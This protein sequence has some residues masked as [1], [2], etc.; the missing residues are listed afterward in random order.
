MR[1][2]PCEPKVGAD[3]E[4]FLTK[5]D[6]VVPCVGLVEGTKDKP[7]QPPDFVKGFALQEDNV[8][9]EFNV[10]PAS[11]LWA[12]EENLRTARKMLKQYT[13]PEH[14]YI[15]VEHNNFIPKDLRSTQAKT[16]GCEPDFDAYSGGE[17]RTFCGVLGNTRTCGGHIHLGGDFN[18][19][20]FVAALFADLLIGTLPDVRSRGGPRA[21][22]YGKAGIY[23][24]KPYGIE[25]RTPSNRWFSDRS[26]IHNAGCAAYHLARYLT[27][28]DAATI[29]LAFKAIPWTMIREYANPGPRDYAI[30]N[31]IYELCRQHD[32]P[33]MQGDEDEEDRWDEEDE[34][35]EEDWE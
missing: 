3:V 11:S 12:W 18:C 16:I 19:P 21:E 4:V 22:W 35:E 33:F 17:E 24:P 26:T 5:D 20:D 14:K 2:E 32:L 23:R 1:K 15:V 6:H 34:E 29:R 31:D 25:Y 28:S 10:P 30:E 8:M 27:Y 7:W 13:P 9:L